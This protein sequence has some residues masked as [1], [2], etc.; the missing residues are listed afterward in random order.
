[1]TPEELQQKAD[2]LDAE[3]M[4]LLEAGRKDEAHEKFV[5]AE[6]LM[7]V[8]RRRLTAE[9]AARSIRSMPAQVQVPEAVKRGKSRSTRN[10][11]AQLAFYKHGKTIKDVAKE[12]G[13]TRALVTAWMSDDPEANRQ[14]PRHQAE[15][16]RRDYGV[17]LSAWRRIRD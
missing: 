2:A 4:R 10:H 3:G 5:Q 15:R 13:E 17:P 6:Q 9:K 1:M 14:I 11:P 16:L 8:V 12:I 7:E